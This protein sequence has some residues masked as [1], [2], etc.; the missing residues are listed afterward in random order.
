MNPQQ[1]GIMSLKHGY[2]AES[3]IEAVN[4]K[5]EDMD[6]QNLIDL[7]IDGEVNFYLGKADAIDV[8][9]LMEEYG[10]TIVPE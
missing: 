10:S 6:I 2:D 8:K 7:A 4:N 3:I 9:E 5:V 1:K